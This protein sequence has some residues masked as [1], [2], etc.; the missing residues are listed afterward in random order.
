ML[1]ARAKVFIS[2][3]SSGTWVA[4]Q[5]AL[6]VEQCGAGTFL[7]AAHIQHGDGATGISEFDQLAAVL[8]R[9]YRALLRH[10]GL[11]SLRQ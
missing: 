11:P 3:S 2:H 9:V 8:R 5:I 10:L 1:G 6:K 7:D 4:K